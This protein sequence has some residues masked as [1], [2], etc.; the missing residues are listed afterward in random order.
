MVTGICD[1]RLIGDGCVV[2]CNY[3]LLFYFYLRYI[4]IIVYK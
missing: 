3:I 4:V 2:D 1:Y